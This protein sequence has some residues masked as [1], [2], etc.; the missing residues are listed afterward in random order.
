M[1]EQNQALDTIKAMQAE[2]M[3]NSNL[4][5]VG[6]AG[7]NP[8]ENLRVAFEGVIDRVNKGEAS[9]DKELAVIQQLSKNAAAAAPQLA[10]SKGLD[11]TDVRQQM[12]A[13]TLTLHNRGL[14]RNVE[15]VVAAE[16]A[17]LGR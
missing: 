7:S 17:N 3:K 5:I 6:A 1:S 8:R 2:E 14:D 16:V 4:H 10:D 15:A 11:A 12:L 9:A 13:S